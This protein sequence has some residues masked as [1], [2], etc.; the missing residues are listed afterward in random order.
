MTCLKRFIRIEKTAMLRRSENGEAVSGVQICRR[1]PRISHL[2]F[3]DDCIVFGKASMEEG[4]KVT[5]ILEDYERESG[6]KL[7]K[8]KTSLFF[9]KNTAVEVKEGVKELFGAEIIHQ[10]ERYLGLPPLVGRGKRKAFNRIK[11][12]VGRKIASWKGRL[13]STAGREILIKAVAQATPTYTMNCFLL[14][15]SL[16]SELNSMVRNFWWGQRDKEKKLAWI[17]W[18]KMCKPKADG[19]MGF[20]DLKAFN[21]ALLAKQGW[22]L[23]QNPCSL[24]HR[25]LKARYFPGNNFMEAQLGNMPS[26]TWRSLLAAREILERG[27]RWS[28]GNGQKVQIWAD[29]WLPTPHSFKVISPKP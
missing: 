21:L 18:G 6:Q 23:S 28:I 8:E 22:R 7:N 15:D 13:L 19:G 11:D 17:A 26:Y 16:C 24:A 3:A 14:P 1:A 12:Q 5:K 4:L 25:V 27:M 2:L 29:R 10:H 20:K 9:S